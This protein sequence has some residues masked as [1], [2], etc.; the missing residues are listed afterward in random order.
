MGDVLQEGV[1]FERG[2]LLLAD[3]YIQTG[4][5]DIAIELLKKCLQFNQVLFTVHCVYA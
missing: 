4:K 3:V 2:W 5:Y 1:W